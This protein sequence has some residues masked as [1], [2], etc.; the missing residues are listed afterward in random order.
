MKRFWLKFPPIIA[1]D[2]CQATIYQGPQGILTNFVQM[3]RSL[4]WDLRGRQ[5]QT[6]Q[7]IAVFKM[8]KIFWPVFSLYHRLSQTS[9]NNFMGSTSYFDN[10]F[11]TYKGIFLGPKRL[12]KTQI[13]E[14]RKSFQWWKDIELFSSFYRTWQMSGNNVWESTRFFDKYCGNDRIISLGPNK[15]I[16]INISRN[17]CF[18]EDKCFLAHFSS[19]HRVWKIS[20]NKW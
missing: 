19:Y 6:F 9:G 11:I 14:K 20:R 17:S 3:I 13:F 4:L 18:H 1:H 12:L 7:N 15:S 8:T 5:K 10:Y 2:K 16:E